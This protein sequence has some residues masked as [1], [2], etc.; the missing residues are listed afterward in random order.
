MSNIIGSFKPYSVFSFQNISDA[1]VKMPLAQTFSLSE[2]RSLLHCKCLSR[3]GVGETL[4]KL[5]VTLRKV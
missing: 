2:F 5:N 1:A 4:A 3:I